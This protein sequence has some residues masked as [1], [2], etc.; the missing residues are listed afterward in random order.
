MVRRP[1]FSTLRTVEPVAMVAPPT[2]VLCPATDPRAYVVVIGS[3]LDDPLCARDLDVVYGRCS[4][5]L[6]RDLVQKW[7][8]KQPYS[9][10]LKNLPLDIHDGAPFHHVS[11]VWPYSLTVTLLGKPEFVH[12]PNDLSTAI[13]QMSLRPMRLSYYQ[14]S[15]GNSHSYMGNG[16][17]A[18]W[19]A[20]DKLHREEK[21]AVFKQFIGLETALD[22]TEAEIKENIHHYSHGLLEHAGCRFNRRNTGD[23]VFAWP[24]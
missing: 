12:N 16:R 1:S 4:E 23:Y 9:A 6:A 24:C 8:D 2:P 7:M 21:L 13:R 18:I 19:T 20:L 14:M 15:L 3:A 17:E 5:V 11:K 22:M 10:V